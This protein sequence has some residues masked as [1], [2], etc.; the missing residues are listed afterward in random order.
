MLR[1]LIVP[2]VVQAEWVMGVRLHDCVVG[3]SA[4]L[5]IGASVV[6]ADAEAVLNAPGFLPAKVFGTAL[7]YQS[8]VVQSD[9]FWAG[10]SSFVSLSLQGAR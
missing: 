10:V 5:G 3:R 4:L 6:A 7:A 8:Q 1:L 2:W 9:C